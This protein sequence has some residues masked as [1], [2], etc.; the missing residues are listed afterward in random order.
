MA[1][2]ILPS[3]LSSCIV[4]VVE[5]HALLPVTTGELED[6]MLLPLPRSRSL[7]ESLPIDVPP[8]VPPPSVPPAEAILLV[9]VILTGTLKYKVFDR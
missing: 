1:Y 2:Y 3:M 4:P 7:P 6:P 8:V 9:V 5:V